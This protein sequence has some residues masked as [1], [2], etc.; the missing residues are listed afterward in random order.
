MDG[1]LPNGFTFSREPRESHWHLDLPRTRLDGCNVLL[2][3]VWKRGPSLLWNCYKRIGRVNQYP[4]LLLF[5]R[6]AGKFDL[7]LIHHSV[8]FPPQVSRRARA[9]TGNWSEHADDAVRK[10]NCARIR[11]TSE[12]LRGSA[13]AGH[14]SCVDPSFSVVERNEV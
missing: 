8:L 3:V 1:R 2:C 13:K 4:L 5:I 7:D 9:A 11:Q 14:E 6:G 10:F 12:Y